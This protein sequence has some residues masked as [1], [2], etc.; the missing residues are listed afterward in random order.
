MF[1]TIMNHKSIRS[2]KPDP[3]SDHDLNEILLAGSRASTI[4]NMQLYSIIITQDK[5]NREKLAP[6]HFNQSMVTEAPVVLTFCADIHRFHKWCEYRDAEP[7]YD[8][9]LWFFNAAID[10]LLACQNVC[11]A[12]EEKGMGICYLGTAVYMAEGIINTLNLPKGVVPVTAITLGY[13]AENP[14]LTDR[15]PLEGVVHRETYQAYTKEAI[16]NIYKEKEALRETLDLLKENNKET[17]A[18]VFTDNR[19]KKDD[20]LVF[21]KKYLEVIEKQGMMNNG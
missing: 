17:L 6:L 1:N 16:D 12:A 11:I 4:G 15:L 19:Y 18:Q 9:F 7:A 21:S 3:V 5:E 10:A 13:P 20:N 14:G 8:N 2:Y